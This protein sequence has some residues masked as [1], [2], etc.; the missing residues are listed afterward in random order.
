[1]LVLLASFSVAV[2][3][4]AVAAC[5]IQV[6][7]PDISIDCVEVDFPNEHVLYC[8]GGEKPLPSPSDSGV[9]HG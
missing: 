2:V 8:D 3:S 5:T 1:M 7:K 9:D 4:V 6:G